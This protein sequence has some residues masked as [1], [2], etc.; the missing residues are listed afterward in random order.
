MIISAI[1]DGISN[2]MF[3]YACGKSLSIEHHTEFLIDISWFENIESR[4]TTRLFLLNKFHITANIADNKQ[5]RAFKE[6]KYPPIINSIY[7]RWQYA[8]PYYKRKE[9]KE[10][11][12]GYDSNIWKSSKSIHLSGFWQSYKYFE[13][14]RTVLLKEFMPKNISE[15]NQVIAK[16]ILNNDDSV[17]IH[18]RRGDYVNSQ[19]THYCLPQ[20]YYTQAIEFI[21]SKVANIHLYVFSDDPEWVFE[22]IKFTCD[23]TLIQHNKSNPEIDIYL[24]SCCKHNIIANSSFS[25][26]GA[27]LNQNEKKIVVAPDKWLNYNFK[28]TVD[29]IPSDW[30]KL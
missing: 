10:T 26:W 14:I 27:W 12:S 29:L 1:T 30:F 5:I 28:S 18:F 19:N 23:Y 16:S 7:W 15:N 6:P 13:N 4:F 11:K 25:W 24:M 9:F 2:Q 20:S 17:S 21:K 8:L 3:Q 22:N